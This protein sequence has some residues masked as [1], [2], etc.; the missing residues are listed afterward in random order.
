VASVAGRIRF[1]D[2]TPMTGVSIGVFGEWTN[3]SITDAEG[4]FHVHAAS[5]V[6]EGLVVWGPDQYAVSLASLKLKPDERTTL[7]LTVDRGL[8]LDAHVVDA[9]TGEPVAGAK[10]VLRR[11]GAHVSNSMQGGFAFATTDAG[12]AF[13]FPFLPA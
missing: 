10:I 7:D 5:P 12:G 6:H 2:G 8:R 4:R 9:G 11:P 1:A 3:H 13:A